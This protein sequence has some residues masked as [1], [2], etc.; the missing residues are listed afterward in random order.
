MQ[1]HRH[2]HFQR[3]VFHFVPPCGHAI[4]SSESPQRRSEWSAQ[5]HCGRWARGTARPHVGEL[6]VGSGRGRSPAS[7]IRRYSE[8]RTPSRSTSSIDSSDKTGSSRPGSAAPDRVA[9]EGNDKL[10]RPLA[11]ATARRT[12]GPHV[13]RAV[14]GQK[15]VQYEPQLVCYSGPRREGGSIKVQHCVS[16]YP[17]RS[18]AVVPQTNEIPTRA[19]RSRIH[20]CRARRSRHGTVVVSVLRM[21]MPFAQ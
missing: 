11:H 16:R 18:V 15:R 4:W 8:T 5:L 6:L 7:C 14:Q 9:A 13:T 21:R 10:I 19:R 17:A 20:R 1:A 3:C 2:H 12:R